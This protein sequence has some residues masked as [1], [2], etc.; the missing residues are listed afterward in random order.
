LPDFVSHAACDRL[1]VRAEELVRDFDPAGIVSIFSTA[2]RPGPAM[3]IS[4]SQA[5]R[6]DSSL[7]RMLLI[8]TAR[9]GKARAL[10]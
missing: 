7:K 1:R 8:P 6:S 2:S 4:W 3:T 5:T 10:N 9:C